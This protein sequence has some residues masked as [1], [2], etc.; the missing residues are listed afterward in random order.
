MLFASRVG[1]RSPSNRKMQ[2]LSFQLLIIKGSLVVNGI[3]ALLR[4]GEMATSHLWVQALF[5]CAMFFYSQKRF[6]QFQPTMNQ[7]TKSVA[8]CRVSTWLC[9]R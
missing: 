3:L 4:E 5:Y 9:I 7:M 8:F 6:A 1:I 2:F